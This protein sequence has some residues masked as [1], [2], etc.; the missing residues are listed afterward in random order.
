MH[1]GL[2]A[3]KTPN[4]PAYIMADSGKAVS[5]LELEQRS[6]QIAHL[7]R[8]LG[9][10][11]GDHVAFLLEN[12]PLFLQIAWGAHRAG[13]YYTAIS[14]RLQPA[15]VAHIIND[16][17]AQVLFASNESLPIASALNDQTKGLRH[18]FI[19]DN[20]EGHTTLEAA[21]ASQPTTPIA[22]ESEG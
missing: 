3:A 19:A 17:G 6:N 21:I 12:H 7:L 1:P 10:K 5:F 13:L 15:E 22:D 2:I 9:L 16:C 11:P 18:I 20:V 8:Q 4:K 14:Y